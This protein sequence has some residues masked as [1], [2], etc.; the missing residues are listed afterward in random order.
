MSVTSFPTTPSE[1][2]EAWIERIL[3]QNLPNAIEVKTISIN[4]EGEDEKSG[5]LRYQTMGI[6]RGVVVGVGG[7]GQL[8]PWISKC[9]II[10]KNFEFLCH[11]FLHIEVSVTIGLKNQLRVGTFGGC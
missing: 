3:L 6:R 1:I 4:T 7:V 8:T 2:T 5:T 10:F 9:R 11:Q